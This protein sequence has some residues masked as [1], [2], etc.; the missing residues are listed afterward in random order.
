M[1]GLVTLGLK[2]LMEPRNA[3]YGHAHVGA[4]WSLFVPSFDWL[5]EQNVVHTMLSK[6]WHA[7]TKVCFVE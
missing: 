7:K 2:R 5:E 1:T 3:G 4:I 6:D